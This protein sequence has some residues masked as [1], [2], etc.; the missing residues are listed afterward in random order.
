MPASRMRRSTA[1]R[2]VWVAQGASLRAASAVRVLQPAPAVSVLRR[3][4]AE[5]LAARC[6]PVRAA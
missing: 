1:V 6:K 5:R 2:V 4:Q 3:L